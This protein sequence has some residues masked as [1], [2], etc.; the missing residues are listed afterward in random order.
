VTKILVIVL[1]LFIAYWLLKRY[2]KGASRREGESRS[3]GSEDMVR[4]VQCGLHLPRSESIAVKS[5]YFCCAEHARERQR[6][7]GS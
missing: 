7:D 6:S 5:E 1:G 4:C 2:L 3:G